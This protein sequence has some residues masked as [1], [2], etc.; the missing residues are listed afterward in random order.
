MIAKL[1]NP[2]AAAALG[3]TISVALGVTAS[4]RLL[5]PL[6]EKM[7]V[8]VAKK[9]DVTELKQKGWDFW[10]IEI[11]ELSNELKG[12]RA[13][14]K[15]RAELLDQRAER[16]AAE[17]KEFAR[18]RADVEGMRRDIGE[19]IVAITA[20]ESKNLRTLAA[21]YATLTPRAAVTIIKEMDDATAVKILSLLKTD[22]VGPIFE[23]MGRASGSDTQLARRAAM[24]SD[25][26]RA[27]KVTKPAPSS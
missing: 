26:I 14:L 23:E 11:D 12:E 25:K 6:M 19:R 4:L 13:I 27:M 24:L 7:I 3:L 5:T 18:L 22:V 21:T 1:Q 8:P 9:K 15:K 10:T 16:L 17:E 20:D 2:Y